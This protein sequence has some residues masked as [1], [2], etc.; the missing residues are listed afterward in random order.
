MVAAFAANLFKGAVSSFVDGA[1]GGHFS[2]KQGRYNEKLRRQHYGF[3][4]G[5]GLTP[6]EIMGG[7]GGSSGGGGG[8]AVLGNGDAISDQLQR[9]MMERNV[10]LS[11]ATQ[12]KVAETQRQT[13][14]DV[15][16]MQ[17]GE[18]SPSRMTAEA[19]WKNATT[20]EKQLAVN[21]VQAVI[22]NNRLR[23]DTEKW[24]A[25]SWQQTQAYK[26]FELMAKMGPENV[27]A[28]VYMNQFERITGKSPFLPGGE[29]LTEEEF[30]SLVGTLMKGSAASEVIKF[31]AAMGAG[32]ALSSFKGEGRM[33]SGR[34][35]FPSKKVMMP[36]DPIF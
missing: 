34:P 2:R 5:Q 15:A 8:A 33:G 28:Q 18:G 1:I 25:V 22:A 19:A 32:M 26:L 27:L 24:N 7:G 3:L 14:L 6:Q 29:P 23:L 31:F 36:A 9:S 16:E 17:Y 30:V 10:Q 11:A 4:R 13:A 12:I 20:N 35:A 21:R